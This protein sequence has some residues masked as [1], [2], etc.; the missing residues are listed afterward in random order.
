MISRVIS[1]DGTAVYIPACLGALCSGKDELIVPIVRV[2]RDYI[3][4]KV[5]VWSHYTN[6]TYRRNY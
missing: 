4:D 3:T 1:F 6:L 5:V 2:E